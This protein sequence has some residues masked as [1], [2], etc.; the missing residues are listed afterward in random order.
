MKT[1]FTSQRM[2][3]GTVGPVMV[4]V[5]VAFG[6]ALGVAAMALCLIFTWSRGAWLGCLVALLLYVLCLGHRAMSYVIVGILPTVTLLPLMPDKTIIKSLQQKGV[7]V[8]DEDV[9][10]LTAYE[11]SQ[12]RIVMDVMSE[13]YDSIEMEEQ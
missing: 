1:V 11:K 2:A 5:L 10:K 8:F 9:S 3:P 13:I 7:T 6:A 4:M 12:K